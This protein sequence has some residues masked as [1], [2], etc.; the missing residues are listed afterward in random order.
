VLPPGAQPRFPATRD[1]VPHDG[2]SRQPATRPASQEPTRETKAQDW[3]LHLMAVDERVVRRAA[4]EGV[5]NLFL[6]ANRRAVAELMIGF[7]GQGRKRDEILHSEVLT[8]EQRAVLSGILLRD[9]RAFAEETIDKSFADCR[10]AA[11]RERL[12]QRSRELPGLIRQAEQGGDF[13][14]VAGLH[15]ELLDINRRLKSGNF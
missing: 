10:Q 13:E 2:T 14:R 11:L 1:L 12:R 8:E 15:A 9:E 7:P 6:D 4:E 5:D 3:L